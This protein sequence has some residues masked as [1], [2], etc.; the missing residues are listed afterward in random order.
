[1]TIDRVNLTIKICSN[2]L[3]SWDLIRHWLADIWSNN[4]H[5]DRVIA[6][7]MVVATNSYYPAPQTRH[8]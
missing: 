6:I 4:S 1:M 3:T 2:N 7:C 8:P 5:Y